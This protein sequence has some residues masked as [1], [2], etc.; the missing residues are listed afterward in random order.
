MAHLLKEG[1]D[2]FGKKSRDRDKK[3][4]F[5]GREFVDRAV[6]QLKQDINFAN[7][8]CGSDVNYELSSPHLSTL[9]KPRTHRSGRIVPVRRDPKSRHLN[10]QVRKSE[11]DVR[12]ILSYHRVL[13]HG[14]QSGETRCRC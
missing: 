5:V 7:D 11:C 6:R 1:F 9:H 10:T 2:F 8:I 13:F 4:L 3:L 14:V 12:G